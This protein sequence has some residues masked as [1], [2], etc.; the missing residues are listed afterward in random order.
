MGVRADVQHPLACLLSSHLTMEEVYVGVPVTTEVTIVNQTKLSAD[1]CWQK[2]RTPAIV[3]A[4][5]YSFVAVSASDS[6]S[7]C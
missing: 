3:D 7:C 6:G 2:V 5:V 1:F 4:G